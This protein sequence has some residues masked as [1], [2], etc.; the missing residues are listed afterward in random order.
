MK[1][2]F[3]QHCQTRLEKLD[4]IFEESKTKGL[5]IESGRNSY[6]FSDDQPIP[7]RP[8][9]YFLYFCPS[10]GEGHILLLQP[11]K[12][13]KLF[14]YSPDDFWHETSSLNAP[15]WEDCFEIEIF[16]DHNHIWNKIKNL[17]IH[18]FQILSPQPE[19]ALQ[20]GCVET[21][22]NLV[23]QLN[24][25]RT[26]K[27]NYEI[28]CIRKANEIAA[29]GHKKAYD[30][31]LAGRTEMEIFNDY[32]QATNQRETEL[33]Y[34]SI[35][36]FDQNAAILHYQNPKKS[37]RGN[38][39]LIDAGARYNGYCSDITR[40]YTNDQTHPV[41]KEI[42]NALEEGQKELC[43]KVLPTVD[44]LDLHKEAHFLVLRTLIDFNII[45]CSMEEALHLNISN[46]FFPHG[47]GHPL[48]IQVHDVSGK[49]LD[50]YGKVAQP[51]E[52]FPYLRTLRKIQHHDVLTIEP[53]LYF[54]PDFLDELKARDE[55]K[56]CIHWEL[57]DELITCGGIRIED[58]IVASEK[59]AI[60][61]TREF[62]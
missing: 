9:P 5:I 37:G 43:T 42:L 46:S 34:N 36:A 14:Y 41:F 48:G 29:K 33:P 31:F 54:I 11:Q 52:Q 6:Y 58:N 35:V 28:T 17:D 23:N 16:K 2:L 47:L 10:H 22:P 62:L 57:V 8:N 44:Y 3:I 60:N 25:L 55:T 20:S 30:S 13:P 40:T 45:R 26:E 1:Q 50:K 7:F 24:W 56:R 18:N 12:K 32:L 38:T 59:E 15:F 61:L 27:T 51:N 49:Q 19:V 4:Q 53:G 21:D 39:L